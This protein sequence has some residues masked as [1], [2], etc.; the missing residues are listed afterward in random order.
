MDESALLSSK[1]NAASALAHLEQGRFSEALSKFLK[2]DPGFTH[3]YHSILSA[4]DVAMYGGILALATLSRKDIYSN[5]LD[6]NA[7]FKE[8]L[9]LVPVLRDAIQ[10]YTRSEYRSCLLLLY[11]LRP[12]L[13]LDLR[14]HSHLDTLLE[15]IRD[16]CL[17]QFF[18]PYSVVSLQSLADC[19]GVDS[20]EDMETII[21]N[22]ILSGKWNGV[23]IH[24]YTQTLHAIS[25]VELE[26]RRKRGTYQKVLQLGDTFMAETQN[27][28]LRLSCIENGLVVKDES[29]GGG[30]KKSSY[31]MGKH[32][33]FSHS[34]EEEDLITS[35]MGYGGGG[36]R[37]EPSHHV[38]DDDADEYE[39]EEDV[40]MMDRED[41]R[42]YYK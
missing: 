24:S 5:M 12:E 15:K 30:N 34:Q 25:P 22:L 26:R 14:F 9:E 3:Q 13:D 33:S 8:R 42:R 2:L 11:S 27:T 31:F 7:S 1:L 16:K 35:Y 41:T 36:S 20:T 28:L 23:R 21:A 37:Y 39:Q 38:V 40:V 4:E 19:I 10:H 32:G 17:I 18:T 29:G 6:S